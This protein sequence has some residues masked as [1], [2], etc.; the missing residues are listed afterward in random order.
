VVLDEPTASLD[1]RAE[2][3]I[4]D[5]VRRLFRDRAVLLISHR[6]ASVRSADRI[7]VLRSGEI[8]EEGDHDALITE[9]GLYAELYNMQAA[10]YQD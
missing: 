2:R 9:N 7:Y 5:S 10:A 8:V 1:A 3:E 4:F 6:F